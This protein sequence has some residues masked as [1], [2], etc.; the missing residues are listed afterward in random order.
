MAR[1]KILFADD[2][3]L[4]DNVSDEESGDWI[5]TRYPDD[6]WNSSFTRAFK[7]T[8]KTVRRLQM[9]GYDV[10]LA[11]TVAE[12]ESY[13]K[14][15]CFDIAIIDLGW[16]ADMAIPENER[17][18]KGWELSNLMEEMDKVHQT[19][20]KQIVYSIK[21]LKDPEL[22]RMAARRGKLPVFKSDSSGEEGRESLMAAISFIGSMMDASS[23][24]EESTLISLKRA[25]ALMADML[26]EP[27]RQYRTWFRVTVGLVSISVVTLV[28]G[29][30]IVLLGEN[31]SLTVLTS[32]SNILT[33]VIAVVLFRELHKARDEVKICREQ[34]I[35]EWKEIARY[36]SNSAD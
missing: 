19:R 26:E 31:Q 8:R 29:V 34:I 1:L 15:Q 11:R 5:R 13:I 36:L 10:T 7:E 32:L 4:P 17:G 12:A 2:Q 16:G 21:F 6:Q 33:N 23:P 18:Y 20:T 24:K 30:L 3:I 14:E 22:S 35:T 9:A 25:Q 28:A 27:L